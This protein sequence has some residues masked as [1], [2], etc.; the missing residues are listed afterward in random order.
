M[1]ERPHVTPQIEI[2][3]TEEIAYAMNPYLTMA[4][5]ARAAGRGHVADVLS[6]IAGYA[7][8]EAGTIFDAGGNIDALIKPGSPLIIPGEKGDFG[9]TIDL[10]REIPVEDR[11]IVYAATAIAKAL[12]REGD[13]E[14]DITNF[15]FQSKPPR[16]RRPSWADYSPEY[17]VIKRK[18]N[19]IK[20]ML[21]ILNNVT[22]DGPSADRPHIENYRSVT[23]LGLV[24][25]TK[26]VR[27]EVNPVTRTRGYDNGSPDSIVLSVKK[28]IPLRI[29]R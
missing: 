18:I 11:H 10:R 5:N 3:R 1:A 29:M 24:L 9:S 26:I 13:K 12:A 23:N 6:I 16:E 2:D 14:I 22:I 8:K 21:G 19:D 7:E 4:D 15:D 25:N 28:I 17:P 20:A 27:R